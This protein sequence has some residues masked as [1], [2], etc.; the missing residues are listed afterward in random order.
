MTDGSPLISRSLSRSPSLAPKNGKLQRIITKTKTNDFD[1][2][3]Q[4]PN[5][6]DYMGPP[7]PTLQPSSS[8]R[9][10]KMAGL[11]LLEY[12]NGKA[13]ITKFR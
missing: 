9:K 2:P 13:D 11:D 8:S 6:L 1:L 5:N 12:V 4:D 3:A 7:L 10:K